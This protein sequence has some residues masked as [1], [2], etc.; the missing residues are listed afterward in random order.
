MGFLSKLNNLINM[1]DE[2]PS[3]PHIR[4]VRVVYV[5]D[6]FDGTKPKTIKTAK[7]ETLPTKEVKKALPELKVEKE[8]IKSKDNPEKEKSIL[9]K[10]ET[11]EKP[12][13]K[14]ENSTES[15]NEET[16]PESVPEAAPLIKPESEVEP[17]PEKEPASAPVTKIV[18]LTNEQQKTIK[19]A[20]I[21]QYTDGKEATGYPTKLTRLLGRDPKRLVNAAIK[22]GLMEPAPIAA[23]LEAMTAADLKKVL[24]KEGLKVSGTK[25]ELAQ[26]IINGSLVDELRK[27][28]K[29][30]QLSDSGKELVKKYYTYVT[31]MSSP[32]AD[33][34][35][36]KDIN[37]AIQKLNCTAE[38]ANYQKV[39]DYLNKENSE[40][41]EEN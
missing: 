29:L 7:T 4:T 19:T 14:D 6:N 12:I 13:V 5:D 25:A 38:E 8:E 37:E 30:Y 34:C 31:I 35:Q 41:T 16:L 39:F 3:Q 23:K 18:P 27:I 1:S 10:D 11:K 20:F 33:T 40:D 28:P 32:L 15:K 22:D 9:A 26:R 36:L 17:L 21:I 24:R 2:S